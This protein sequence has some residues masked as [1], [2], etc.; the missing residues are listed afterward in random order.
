MGEDTEKPLIC[1]IMNQLWS[2]SD[3]GTHVRFWWIPS[4]C[5][6]AGNEKVD[7]LAKES[8][9]HDTDPLARVHYADLKPL[10]NSYIQ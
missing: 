4:H 9:D 6:M 8:L 1:Y 5:G 2:L 10:I 7:Q 3:K